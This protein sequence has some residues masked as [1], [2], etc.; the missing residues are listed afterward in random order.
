MNGTSHHL[1][2][3]N[4]LI[5]PY[6]HPSSK[7]RNLK[8]SAP[9]HSTPCVFPT[10]AGQR[11]HGPRW[12]A[13]AAAST[14]SIAA[15]EEAVPAVPAA[16]AV[17]PAAK[18]AQEA[19]TAAA[20]TV[21]VAAAAPAKAAKTPA[22]DF[23]APTAAMPKRMAVA[24]VPGEEVKAP[25]ATVALAAKAAAPPAAVAAPAAAKDVKAAA[26]DSAVLTGAMP[27]QVMAADAPGAKTVVPAAKPA[28]AAK[29]A[30][31]L[32]AAAASA[33]GKAANAPV[34]VSAAPTAAMPKVGVGTA[35]VVMVVVPSTTT[36][37]AANFAVEPAVAAA[38]AAAQQT[39]RASQCSDR[40]PSVSRRQR[41]HQTMYQWCRFGSSNDESSSDVDLDI[42]DLD[43]ASTPALTKQ[44][45]PAAAKE[46][47]VAAEMT[48]AAEA[49]KVLKKR[50]PPVVAAV[51][52]NA[53]TAVLDLAAARSASAEASAAT[54]M[55]G[56]LA[57]VAA[58]GVVAAP[59]GGGGG[60]VE[61][62]AEVSL[63]KAKT[64]VAPAATLPV[65][66]ER[67]LR[68]C[69]RLP[70]HLPALGE[71]LLPAGSGSTTSSPHSKPWSSISDD[72]SAK[73]THTFDR[74]F[75]QTY[76]DLEEGIYTFGAKFWLASDRSKN[77]LVVPVSGVGNC[78]WETL[79]AAG[80][81][82]DSPEGIQPNYRDYKTATLRYFKSAAFQSLMENLDP[83]DV[84]LQSLSP[85]HSLSERESVESSLTEDGAYGCEVIYQLA[86]LALN[87]DITVEDIASPGYQLAFL[88]GT[89]SGHPARAQVLLLLRNHGELP[90]FNSK[91]KP[92]TNSTSKGIFSSGHFWLVL[93]SPLSSNDDPL[94]NGP[95]SELARPKTIEPLFQE[96]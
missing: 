85:L 28:Q 11:P 80:I 61:A 90:V 12:A 6:R 78:F 8:A 2:P 79:A 7:L 3:W 30:A 74:K 84:R 54:C 73:L 47:T 41:R 37:L 39:L 65:V 71:T 57:A 94:G 62:S 19:K 42:N 75:I 18:P 53:A 60:A 52:T 89:I 95:W 44:A 69:K 16:N 64:V 67:L 55:A 86:A 13:V 81:P 88:S 9:A 34:V 23:A 21:V 49:A 87:V 43:S 72:S 38:P 40:S 32:A 20:A 91:F 45:A 22:D 33:P 46:S 66:R 25:A 5:R 10:S 29:A 96:A 83:A 51:A 31:P 68:S 14:A 93:D 56:T 58:P 48:P 15:R 26:E 36:A 35:P 63:P 27:Q 82:G 50:P 59:A 24:A 1:F 76:F 70:G 4:I 92:L 17:V 77:K